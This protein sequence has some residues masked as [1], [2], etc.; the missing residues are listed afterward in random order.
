[1]PLVEIAQEDAGARERGRVAD[2]AGEQLHLLATLAQ[3]E[4]EVAVEDVQ[5]AAVDVE[6]DTQASAGLAG[7]EAQVLDRPTQD[8]QPAQHRVTVRAT[9]VKPRDAH[10]EPHAQPVGEVRRL[11]LAGR[12]LLADDLL[13]ADDVGSDLRDDAGDPI[14]VETP[15]EAPPAVDVVAADDDLPH[16]ARDVPR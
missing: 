1:M 4:P 5:G 10:D 7:A 8:G 11:V 14:E 6:V 2:E 3:G 9:A 16:A 12:A 15:I 13:Q